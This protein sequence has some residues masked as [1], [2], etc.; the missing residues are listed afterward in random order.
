MSSIE[1]IKDRLDIADLISETV[2]LRRSGKNQIGFC[3]FHANTR[4]PSF[5]VFP[6]TG[7]WRCFGQCSEGGDIFKFVMKREGWD[8][9]E[10]LS[11]LA[12]QAGVQLRAPSPGEQAK[13]DE[14]VRLRSLLED[15]VT[16]FRHQ[17][18]HTEAGKSTLE[19]LHQRGLNDETIE[20]FGL[21]YAPD[22]WD[23]TL[24]HFLDKGVSVE[25]LMEVGL[26]SEKDE[27][28]YYSKFRH[29][30]MFPIRDARGRMAGFGAR[31]LRADERAKYLNSP[32]TA[33]FDKGHLLYGLDR[34]RKSIRA[35]DQVVIAEGYFD[36]IALHQAGHTNTISPMGTA[37][38]EHQLRQLKRFTRRI[39]LALDADAAGT[40]ATLRGLQVARETMDRE[41]DPIFNARGL[42]RNEARLQADIRVTTLPEGKDPDDIIN[43]RPEDWREILEAAKPIVV[44]VMETLAEG[45]DLEDPKVKTEI[46]SQVVPLIQDLPSA[47][48]RDT[49][50]QRLARFLH[51]SEETLLLERSRPS[52]RRPRRPVVRTK[53]NDAPA[54]EHDAPQ[55]KLSTHI[56][57]KLELHSLG[58]IMRHPE[59]LY[60]VDRAL[61]EAGLER[62]SSNDFQLTDHQVMFRLSLESLN[63][64]LLEPVNFTMDNLPMPLL[65]LA[66]E[67]LVISQNLDPNEER[68]LEDLMRTIL[69][70]RRINIHQGNEQLQFLQQEAQEQGDQHAIPY[71]QAIVTAVQTMN[72]LDKALGKYTGSSVVSG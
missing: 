70:L 38:T 31:A 64:D 60:R 46:A 32:Q 25:E 57:V 4:T 20:A 8:F 50:L 47:I 26:I 53:T 16:Y 11:H 15:A 40:K 23:T 10:A 44:H 33:V 52:N 58:I 36:V 45:K 1:E 62:I 56:S 49:F 2:K 68:V 13:K 27:G 28:G 67:I 69:K 51:V 14:N 5:V 63:Q 22:G 12:K 30:V 55:G 54:N 39:I 3:P 19:Y 42:L 41:A 72:H 48:E 37:L 17:L 29:R 18:L 61:G 6:D 71:Q 21:G 9:P 59:L 65:D 35:E 34:A 7:T 24:Q 43:Q 66:D